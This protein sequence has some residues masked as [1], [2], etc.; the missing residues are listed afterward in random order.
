MFCGLIVL[1]ATGEDTVKS[2]DSV[3][4]GGDNRCVH[5]VSQ[6]HAVG[7]SKFASAER[8]Q[9]AHTNEELTALMNVPIKE[10]NY[11]RFLPSCRCTKWES[12]PSVSP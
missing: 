4:T 10:D 11:E 6:L 9:V 1:N 3:G 7:E 12:L 5:P 8:K 2:P